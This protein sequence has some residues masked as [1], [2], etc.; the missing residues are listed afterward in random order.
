MAY[1][2]VVFNNSTGSNTQASGA[3]PGDGTTPGSALYGSVGG[4]TSG[5]RFGFWDGDSLDLSNVATD[6][7]HL[8]YIPSSTTRRWTRI[9]G[10][11]DTY[12]N[13]TCDTTSG[14]NVLT[15]VS[16]VAGLSVG[17][18]IDSTEIS[19][20]GEI[21]SID[22]VAMTITL[23]FNAGFTQSGVNYKCPKQVTC[24]E[25][26]NLSSGYAIG[27]KRQDFE[28]SNTHSKLLF[29][30]NNWK[31]GWIAHL[32]D[33]GTEYLQST[34]AIALA[35]SGDTTDGRCK[36]I[37][38]NGR[39]K[40]TCITSAGNI[41]TLAGTD[42]WDIENIEFE[43]N[44]ATGRGIA[45]A[46][47]SS[48]STDVRV[49]DCVFNGQSA[50]IGTGSGWTRL[51]IINCEIKNNTNK[52][53]PLLNM[54]NSTVDVI[55][56]DIHHNANPYIFH[57]GTNAVTNYTFKDNR[58]YSNY[59]SV[60]GQT[61]ATM[62]AH[63]WNIVGNSFYDNGD[64]VIRIGGSAAGSGASYI[65]Q[66]N[67][68]YGNHGY[69]VDA[70]NISNQQV[71][72][73]LFPLNRNN[74]WGDNDSGSYRNFP[75]G[76]NDK[77]LTENPFTKD[78]AGLYDDAILA[79]SP[80]GYWRL[81]EA[82]GTTA[83]DT[84]GNNR[85]GTYVG[86]PTLGVSG[87][88]VDDA[89]T[90]ISISGSTQYVEV[91]TSGLELTGSLTIGAWL[92]RTGSGGTAQGVVSKANPSNTGYSFYRSSTG[93]IGMSIDGT[94]YE[95]LAS[96]DF[97]TRWSFY[98]VTLSG[99]TLRLYQNGIMVASIAAE[100]LDTTNTNTLKIGGNSSNTTDWFQGDIDEVF[101]INSAL[102]LDEVQDLYSKAKLVTRFTLNDASG[103]GELLKGERYPKTF[104]NGVTISYGDIGA[105]QEKNGIR[106]VG[107]N[108]GFRG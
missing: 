19:L 50:A 17:D 79:F 73:I 2:V 107:M 72:K 66:N 13:F 108:G 38:T 102:T 98:V 45:I 84:S 49:I 94:F 99:S 42:Y 85:N 68:F 71:Q 47:T 40:I 20:S 61:N 41:F 81:G 53:T 39:P 26:F 22:S 18:F 60:L 87:P 24:E 31:A 10:K 62:S 57:S 58:V 15:N 69:G 92:R 23:P 63:K 16:S 105:I 77:T 101:I 80:V 7:S 74:A 32:E 9:L 5:T 67:I 103:G 93:S 1:P 44:H 97:D 36:I 30:T 8:L 6:G 89:D 96:T 43:H 21:V 104:P 33:T 37:G 83:T 65:I 46:N 78:T 88:L 29:G 64:T 70:T 35:V 90:A 55:G 54:P 91:P 4:S 82:I 27:G 56:C 86:S 51:L 34:G 100:T 48:Q 25:S 95:L 76:T 14:S 75:D 3:G 28:T 59:G 106:P 52:A 12:Q 11:K